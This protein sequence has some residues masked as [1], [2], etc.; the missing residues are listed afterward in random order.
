MQ[1]IKGITK[2]EYFKQYR[3]NNKAKLDLRLK[4]WYKAHKDRVKLKRKESYKNNKE[5][6]L[7]KCAEYY[8]KN[9]DK[10]KS[11]AQDNKTKI[12]KRLKIWHKNNRAKCVQYKY[13]HYKD[14]IVLE[15]VD[16]DKLKQMYDNKCVYCG[17]ELDDSFHIDHLLPVARY[18]KIGKKC[19]HSYNN[20]APTHGHCNESKHDK[21]PLEFLWVK[22]EN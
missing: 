6:V 18:K 4:L 19:P 14:I 11:Y 8:I 12:S 7:N 15:Y 16:R 21:T 3:E 17:Q 13:N 20:C 22:D 9:K 5:L 10:K 2:K 1:L